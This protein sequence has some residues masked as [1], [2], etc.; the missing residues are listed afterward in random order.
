MFKAI[1]PSRPWPKGE[2]TTEKWKQVPAFWVPIGEL[3]A[4]QDG[5]KLEYLTH[6]DRGRPSFSGDPNPHVVSWRG[7]LYLEDGHHRA[8][9]AMMQAKK[10]I[11]ARVLTV[12][13]HGE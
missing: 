3:I 10:E 8:V 6:G 7:N 11:F 5:V 1:D 4:T 13:D 2:M 9:R 12:I